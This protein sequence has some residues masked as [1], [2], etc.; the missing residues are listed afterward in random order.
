M[1][2]RVKK[3]REESKRGKGEE[4]RRNEGGGGEGRTA[5]DDVKQLCRTVPNNFSHL[6]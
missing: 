6:H 3:T 4:G 2:I 5:S 1:K